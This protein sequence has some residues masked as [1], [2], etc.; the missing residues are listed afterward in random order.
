MEEFGDC[1][2]VHQVDNG[3]DELSFATGDAF[4]IWEEFA[5]LIVDVVPE[6]RSGVRRTNSNG[7]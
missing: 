7:V 5:A 4:A 1:V 2:D 3:E 6:L